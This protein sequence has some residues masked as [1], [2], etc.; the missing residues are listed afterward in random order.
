MFC[1]GVKVNSFGYFVKLREIDKIINFLG[2][3][4]IINKIFRYL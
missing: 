1:G 4:D 2:F 3:V